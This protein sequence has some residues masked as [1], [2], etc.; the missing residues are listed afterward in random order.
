MNLPWVNA[1]FE[2]GNC[3]MVCHTD[4]SDHEEYIY[5]NMFQGWTCSRPA[6]RVLINDSKYN[7]VHE[8]VTPGWN[9]SVHVIKFSVLVCEVPDN[10]TLDGWNV[11]TSSRPAGSQFA[12]P[13]NVTLYCD[14][15]WRF[16]DGSLSKVFP[17]GGDC[18]TWENCSG[19]CVRI[20]D[21]THPHRPSQYNSP[22]T[23][24]EPPSTVL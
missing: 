16:P 12:V 23:H 15:L 22:P 10:T 2:N 9:T 1:I 24:T 19:E 4:R 17:C 8:V 3:V 6:G 20:L 21:P 5:I 18:M 11:E 13:D 7:Y 14:P